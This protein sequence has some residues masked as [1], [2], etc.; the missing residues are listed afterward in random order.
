MTFLRLWIGGAWLL[1]GAGAVARAQQSPLPT[2]ASYAGALGTVQAALSGQ[3][4][5][6]RD[7]VPSTPDSIAVERLVHQRLN[8]FS[9]VA[10]PGGAPQP[11]S[12]TAL[13]QALRRAAGLPTAQERATAYAQAAQQIAALRAAL[14][15]SKAGVSPKSAQASVQAVLGRAEFDSD[16]LPPP[17]LL[18]RLSDW[19][20]RLISR[21]H[22]AAGP[23]PTLSPAFIKTLLIVVAAGAFALLVAVLVQYLRQR[24]RPP[25]ALALS[26][27][28]EALVEARDADSLRALAEEQGRQGEWRRAFRLTYLAALVALDT[29]GTLRFDR[30][31]TNW[32]YLRALRA[33]GQGGTSAA[34]LPFTREFDRIWYGGAQAGGSDYAY[35]VAQYQSLTLSQSTAAVPEAAVSS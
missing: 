6:L 5:R 17:S 29:H 13:E 19:L 16:P 30:S 18:E 10:A 23:A 34:L 35:A 4:A 15:S 28:E 26:E 25:G 3:S 21:R 9:V 14:L 7:A 31:K 32:E 11:V 2:V 27:E 1:I 33:A 20:G 24:A 8:A 12:S 22:R